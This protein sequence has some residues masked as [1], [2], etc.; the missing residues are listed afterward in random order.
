MNNT[1][2]PAQYFDKTHA[3]YE[4]ANALMEQHLDRVMFSSEV[5]LTSYVDQLQGSTTPDFSD[6]LE[7][8]PAGDLRRNWLSERTVMIRSTSKRIMRAM[9]SIVPPINVRLCRPDEW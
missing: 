5:E 7:T 6:V 2:T 3:D 4:Q 1:L 9:D 8:I